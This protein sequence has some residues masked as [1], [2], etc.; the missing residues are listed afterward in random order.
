VDVLAGEGALEDGTRDDGR[1]AVVDDDDDDADADAA[2]AAAA[3]ADDDDVDV[4]V[5]AT[6]TAGGA[7]DTDEEDDFEPSSTEVA[8]LVAAGEELEGVW[9]EETGCVGAIPAAG[10]D[11]DSVVEEEGTGEWGGADG[12]T[13]CWGP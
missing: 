5:V 11:E 1:A 3:A 13:G 2:A 12:S 7:S 4:D 9:E 6:E 8:I 10:G